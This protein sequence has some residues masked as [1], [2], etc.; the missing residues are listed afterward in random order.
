M[1]KK[2]KSVGGGQRS[3]RTT[4][5]F[6]RKGVRHAPLAHTHTPTHRETHTRPNKRHLKV[7]WTLVGVYVKVALDLPEAKK[8]WLKWRENAV[9]KL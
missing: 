3:R 6:T 1:K 8:S 4:A 5:K 2:K 7:I 9:G